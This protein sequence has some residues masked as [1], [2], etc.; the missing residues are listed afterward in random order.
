MDGPWETW[1][2]SLSPPQSQIS[3]VL[4]HPGFSELPILGF[5]IH[6][7]P[8]MITEHSEVRQGRHGWGLYAESVNSPCDPWFKEKVKVLIV[9]L[10]LTLWDPID[11]SLPGSL[12]HGIS[13]AT[14]LEWLLFRSPRDLSNPGI[15]SVALDRG[16]FTVWASR[17]AGM[18]A[19]RPRNKH[20]NSIF[21]AF[22]AS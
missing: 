8:A 13:Q 7:L 2:L 17:E 21:S 9:Q 14:M 11:G 20:L 5:S 3:K 6:V 1:A 22:S 15:V 18:W 19:N 4:G 12:V 16:F 10:C